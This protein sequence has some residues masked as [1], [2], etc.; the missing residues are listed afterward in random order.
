LDTV[1]GDH[2]WVASGVSV[3]K[4]SRIGDGSILACGSVVHKVTIPPHSLAGGTPCRVLAE[5]KTWRRDI[6][7]VAEGC[8]RQPLRENGVKEGMQPSADPSSRGVA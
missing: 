8:E 7:T 6:R 4:G 1:I 3:L 5:N 2:V